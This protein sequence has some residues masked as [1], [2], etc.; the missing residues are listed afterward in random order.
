MN[1]YE[2]FSFGLARSICAAFPTL[3]EKSRAVIYISHIQYE[4]GLPNTVYEEMHK[5]FLYDFATVSICIS[6]YMRKFLF[7]FLSVYNDPV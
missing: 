4:E 5:Y 7:Y 6:L 2:T 1:I 3:I